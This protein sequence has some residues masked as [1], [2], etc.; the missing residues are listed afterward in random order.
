LPDTEDILNGLLDSINKA[1]DEVD[2]SYERNNKA[3]EQRAA[4]RR[5]IGPDDDFVD[6]SGL[7][8]AGNSQRPRA[9]LKRA[10]SED[11][12]LAQFEQSLDDSES[13]RGEAPA[14]SGSEK[15]DLPD[16]EDVSPYF[17]SIGQP[18]KKD[19]SNPRDDLIDNIDTIVSNAKKKAGDSILPDKKPEPKPEPGKKEAPKPKEKKQAAKSVDVETDS[20]KQE[21]DD[22]LLQP[23]FASDMFDNDDFSDTSAKDVNLMDESGDDRDLSDMLAGDGELT[24]IGDMLEADE[25]GT[26]L[27]ESA[28][29]FEDS[30]ESE[31]PDLD[32]EIPGADSEPS[33][34]SPAPKDDAPKKKGLAALIEKIKSIFSKSGEGDGEVT[35]SDIIGDHDISPDDLAAENEGIMAEAAKQEE[36]KE[37]KKKKA[38]KEKP[39]KAPKEKKPKAKKEPKPKKPKPVDNSPLVPKNVIVV[40][41][42]LAISLFALIFAAINILPQSQQKKSLKAEYT[43]QQYPVVYAKL[44]GRDPD[45]L[46]DD[47]KKM[48][49]SSKLAGELSVKYSIYEGA[50]KRKEYDYALDALIR[51]KAAYEENK[52]KASSL[53]IKSYYEDYG[54]RISSALK[55]Q[56]EISD[57]EAKKLAAIDDREDYTNQIKAILKQ[58]GLT[59]A[60][61]SNN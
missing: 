60:D 50:M 17:S 9:N 49:E 31:V 30:A 26:V 2:S 4:K 22:P 23:E 43:Q 53:D 28:D 46:S 61:D 35:E 39:K 24:D 40:F 55:E 37:K 38:K 27:K 14:S 36:A 47:E 3:A 59:P 58:K 33:G 56:F 1:Q 20:A 57:S 44:A 19:S 42:V 52:S 5:E 13:Q 18:K 34:D 16:G 48:L 41:F 8:D 7:S 45:K 12:F 11:D 32:G 51:G 25:N 29:K 6:K 15:Y 21:E 10:L 54:K